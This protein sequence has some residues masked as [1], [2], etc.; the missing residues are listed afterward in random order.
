MVVGVDVLD[1]YAGTGAM[2]IEALSRGAAGAVLVERDRAEAAVCRRN[3]EA[4]GFADRARVVEGPVAR[5][6]EGPTPPE[7]PFAL[8]CIDPPYEIDDHEV[9]RVLAM[10]SG[11]GW[12]S[13][14]A[15]VVVERAVGSPLAAI[16][17]GWE[18]RTA[19]VYG[20]TLVTLLRVGT[21]DDTT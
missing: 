6:L 2:A 15:A 20:D 10:L 7:A 18:L 9:A 19:R 4:T 5:F 12:V 21:P 17:A 16:P 14:G 1:L 11:A 8:V 13:I 3:V